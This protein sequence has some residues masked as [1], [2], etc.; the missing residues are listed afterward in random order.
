MAKLYAGDTIGPSVDY[1][2][3][4]RKEHDGSKWGSTGGR[5]SGTDVLRLLTERTY[6]Q[7][8]LDFGA[9]KGSLESFI[10][11]RLERKVEW[12]NYDPGIPGIDQIPQKQFD[13]VVSTDVLEHVEPRRIYDTLV[14][15]AILTGKVLYSDIACY[16][17]G[18]VFGEGPYKGQDMH[19]IVEDPSWWRQQFADLAK[20]QEF[21]YEH[22]EHLSKGR[23]KK[24]C[25]M[26]HERV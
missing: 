5:Y 6:I 16:P 17:T 20:L 23:Q 26:I 11:E 10:V 3:H 13:L 9:G 15:L 12:T 14:Q 1:Q 18:K 4:L 7:S 25:V 21:S 24:R 2:E 19:L 8:V 22:R